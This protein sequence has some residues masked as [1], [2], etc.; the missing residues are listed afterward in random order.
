MKICRLCEVPLRFEPGKGWVHPGGG[1][2]VQRCEKCGWMSDAPTVARC[3]TCR[4]GKHL[5]DDH[6]AQPVERNA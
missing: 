2:Y 6:C 3:P 4:D 5:I 1:T